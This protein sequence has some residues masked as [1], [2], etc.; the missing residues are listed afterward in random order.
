MSIGVS[1]YMSKMRFI[2][3]SVIYNK[4][5]DKLANFALS[6][7]SGQLNAK[8]P[9]PS[10]AKDEFLFWFSGFTDAEGNFLI[11]LDRNFVKFRF[12]ISL[13]IDDIGVLNIIRSK[14]NI[15]R[16]TIETS[17]D[18]CSFIVEK[19][20]DIRNVICPIFN[21]YPLH[22]SKRLDFEDFNKAVFIKGE[23]NK[24]LLGG[25]MEKIISLKKGMNSNRE[26]F[27]FQTNKSQIII[28]PN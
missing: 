8:A 13:H 20:A 1:G 16:V 10:E 21:C 7:A 11:T 25:D 15:G 14:L 27:T 17:R 3:F 6:D 26:I 19:Y 23:I 24:P 4:N 2:S 12:K 22:T 5:L 18:R 9:N 28:N